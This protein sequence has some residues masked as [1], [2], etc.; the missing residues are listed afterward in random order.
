[1]AEEMKQVI[2]ASHKRRLQGVVVS[3]KRQKTI[4]VETENYKAHPIYKKRVSVRK[5]YKV[6]DRNDAAK[7]GDVVIFEEC[8]PLSHDKRFILALRGWFGMQLR[9]DIQPSAL[10][11]PG[12]HRPRIAEG[13]RRAYCLH[14][15]HLIGCS[16]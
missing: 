11:P 1:M 9:R 16:L 13:F 12:L 2:E 7:V 5:R 10:L 8:R 4:I 6:D 15:R 14:H 3:H